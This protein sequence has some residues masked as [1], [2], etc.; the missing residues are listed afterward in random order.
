[1]PTGP[2]RYNCDVLRLRK[3]QSMHKPLEAKAVP[4]YIERLL[5]PELE[6]VGFSRDKSNEYHTSHYVFRRTV[7]EHDHSISMEVSDYGFSLTIGIDIYDESAD[8]PLDAK[9]LVGY[10]R[11]GR[12]TREWPCVHTSILDLVKGMTKDD[13]AR[14]TVLE[15]IDVLPEVLSWFQV[16]KTSRHIKNKLVPAY[17]K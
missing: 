3:N 11:P 9:V 12:G 1:M 13:C 6:S 15:C 8:L 16:P 17:G 2:Q 5:I 4:K 10:V 7:G 14:R